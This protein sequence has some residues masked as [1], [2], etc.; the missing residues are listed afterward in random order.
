MK[1]QKKRGWQLFELPKTQVD[2]NMPFAFDLYRFKID[3]I[4]F[5]VTG[6][7]VP[8]ISLLLFRFVGGMNGSKGS[9]WLP[10]V[11]LLIGIIC[12]VVAI[13]YFYQKDSRLF[14]KSGLFI[15]YAFQILPSLVMLIFSP[16]VGMVNNNKEILNLVS[17]WLQILAE[18]LIL[19]FAMWWVTDLKDR[20]IMTFKKNWKMVLIV[21]AV[22]TIVMVGI[23][24]LFGWATKNTPLSGNSE[25]QNSLT[26]LLNSESLAIKIL[27]VISLFALTILVAP[28]VEELAARQAWSIG[29]ANR[30]IA[31][32][33]SAIFFGMM[34]V[35]MGDVEHI[36]DYF[37]A[38]LILST[39][40]NIG[41]GNV[42]YSWV[43]H[44]GSNLVALI[45][46]LIQN[47]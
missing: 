29:V 41:R 14:I 35:S 20:I 1:T 8:F 11:N 40:F 15:F 37:L 25:N 36:L 34:H 23:S 33:T 18:V 16:I 38:G 30:T 5:L 47:F 31:W 21:F 9:E 26:D 7:I 6:L 12:S 3:G 27:A 43:A 39:I 42:T 13:V 17:L 19:A 28:L 10:L 45:M 4:V 2:K 44:A 22:G 46:T 24:L 32:I